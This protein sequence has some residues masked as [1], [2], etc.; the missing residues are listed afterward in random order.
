MTTNRKVRAGPINCAQSGCNGPSEGECMGLCTH[1]V[2]TR[3]LPDDRAAV[4]FGNTVDPI[5]FHG[6]EPDDPGPL[7]TPAARN[8]CLVLVVLIALLW[9]APKYANF[10]I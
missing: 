8:T 10:F 3:H 4:V 1:R 2:N 6:P 7:F 5:Q 9:F